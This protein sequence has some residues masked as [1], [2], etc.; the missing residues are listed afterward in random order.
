MIQYVN[1]IRI[2]RPRRAVFDFLTAPFYWPS[3]LPMTAS[4]TPAE[5]RHFEVGEQVDELLNV[6]GRKIPI[7]WTCKTNDGATHYEIE[8]HSNYGGGSDTYL[9]YLFSGENDF[10]EVEREIRHQFYHPVRSALESVLKLYYIYEARVGL[11]RAK[12]HLEATAA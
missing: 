8:G 1:R 5:M 6:M 10:T 11:S 4:V 2:D 9:S 7:Q 3:Y 12:T